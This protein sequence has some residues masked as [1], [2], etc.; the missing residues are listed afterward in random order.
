[1]T[2]VLEVIETT[3]D[4]LHLVKHT[5]DGALKLSPVAQPLGLATLRV[6][7][8]FAI[9]IKANIVIKHPVSKRCAPALVKMEFVENS[10]D[11][12]IWVNPANQKKLHR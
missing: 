6:I 3:D 12:F 11:R 5:P 4:Q 7:Q 9:S 8:E 10:R 1:M 2:A